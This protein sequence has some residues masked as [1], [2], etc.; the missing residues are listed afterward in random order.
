MSHITTMVYDS[1]APKAPGSRDGFERSIV[2]P[3]SVPSTAVTLAYDR[4]SSQVGC[5]NAPG[6]LTTCTYVESRYTGFYFQPARAYATDTPSGS[7]ESRLIAKLLTL[8]SNPPHTGQ[9]LWWRVWKTVAEDPWLGSQQK[10]IAR[11]L[12]RHQ[13]FIE[14][15]CQVCTIHLGHLFERWPSLGL[16]T[17]ELSSQF[18]R[19]MRRIIRRDFITWLR[20]RSNERRRMTP[21]PAYD[22]V[23]VRKV[24]LIDELEIAA[25]MADLP[26]LH[27]DVVEMRSVGYRRS[28]IARALNISI[29]QVDRIF[30]SCRELLRRRLMPLRRN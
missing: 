11:R 30:S 14:E 25:A 22:F 16:S 23:D 18:A 12:V 13:Q 1:G 2:G 24:Q 7:L 4:S 19:R 20:V 6:V 10:A 3:A 26:L 17:D 29:Y 5:L 28:E 9:P 21:W 27:R 8:L 15:M